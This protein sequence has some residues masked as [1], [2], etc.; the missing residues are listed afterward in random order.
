M[1]ERAAVATL[2]GVEQHALA[3]GVVG[4]DQL[5][6]PELVHH[7]LEDQGA[8]QDDVGPAGVEAGQ[9]GPGLRGGRARQ[10][11]HQLVELRGGEDEVAHRPGS[12]AGGP[13]G[14]HLGQ[15]RDRARRAHRHL[16]VEAAHLASE[17]GDRGPHVTTARVDRAGM[18][19]LPVEEPAGEPDG[20]E[21]ERSGR[22]HVAPL[23]D[24]QLG[25]A[26]TDVAEQQALVVHRHGLQ[27]PEV[28]QPSLL[29]PGDHVDVHPGFRPRAIDELVPV[30]GL[31]DGGGG[32]RGDGRAVH[33]GD[34]P[35]AAEG[36]HGAVDRVGGELAHVAGA[37]AEPHH[38][39]LPL[40]DLEPRTGIARGHPGDD[41]VHGVRADVDGGEGLARRS[42]GRG[43][44]SS[45]VAARGGAG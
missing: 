34:L 20:A 36:G 21:L 6:D 14:S 18:G 31:A 27:H 24:Q 44:A 33:L 42:G 25:A 4:D 38:L 43:H 22:Q 5:R 16:H 26:A 17:R 41:P 3:Q 2:P 29:H 40:E 45:V 11:H 37:G 8:G 19:Q 23:P 9:L 15:R 39:L 10:L 12:A 1:V 35:E 13:Q 32:H 28:D 30:L 7:L